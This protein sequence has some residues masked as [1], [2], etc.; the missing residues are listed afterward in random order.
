MYYVRCCAVHA[1]G[2]DDPT[3]HLLRRIFNNSANRSQDNHATRTEVTGSHGEVHYVFPVIDSNV[4]ITPGKTQRDGVTKPI[5][6]SSGTMTG[7]STGRPSLAG[8]AVPVLH[9][10]TPPPSNFS[11]SIGSADTM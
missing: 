3:S 7:Y 4:Y 11:T 6:D 2:S 9:S 8:L 1:K 10:P 5:I